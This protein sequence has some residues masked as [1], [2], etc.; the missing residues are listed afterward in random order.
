MDNT[1]HFSCIQCAIHHRLASLVP[2]CCIQLDCDYIRV[3]L[4]LG[5]I[6]LAKELQQHKYNT[7]LITINNQYL[8]ANYCCA[9]VVK[10]LEEQH[11]LH[12]GAPV[13]ATR[14]GIIPADPGRSRM[15]TGGRASGTCIYNVC[16]M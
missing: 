5:T 8:S 9:I 16:S 10:V 14:A 4:H 15:P 6:A 7:T 1:Y 13:V 11:P 3:P 2:L 12:H